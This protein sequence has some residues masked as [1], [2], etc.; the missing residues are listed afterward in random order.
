[1]GQ[2]DPP[3]KRGRKL[4]EGRSEDILETVLLLLHESGY[5]QLRMQ[6]VAD[7]AGVGL[8]TIYRRWPTK[9]DVVRA[10]LECDLAQD[11][12]V[13]TG[14]ARADVR[15]FLAKMATDLSG[16][17]AQ[18]MLGFLTSIRS[19]PEIAEV[20]RETAINRMQEHLRSRLASELG[21][22]FPDLDL[23]AAAGPAILIYQAAVCGKPMDAEAMA[24]R[25]TELLF[26][27]LPVSLTE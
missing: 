18:N 11:K 1:M 22:D 8:S 21:E 13:T 9:Q 5:D 16:D 23:R 2:A 3:A 26:A 14:D 12:Y 15:A 20:F 7:R 19:D 27:P 17:G 4:S 10:A 25:L 6:D 24:T